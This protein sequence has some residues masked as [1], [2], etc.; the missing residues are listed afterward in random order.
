[1]TSPKEGGFSLG[2]WGD[3]ALVSS[4]FSLCSTVSLRIFFVCDDD[5]SIQIISVDVV[6]AVIDILSKSERSNAK[7]N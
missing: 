1:M 4:L 7:M 2:R 3:V 6:S 5:L